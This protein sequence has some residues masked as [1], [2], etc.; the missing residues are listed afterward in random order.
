VCPQVAGVHAAAAA[1]VDKPPCRLVTGCVMSLGCPGVA[2]V[3][4]HCNSHRLPVEPCSKQHGASICCVCCLRR[5][6]T[7]L[8]DM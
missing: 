1:A 3:Q 5:I 6:H 2:L 7:Q 8:L 4:S